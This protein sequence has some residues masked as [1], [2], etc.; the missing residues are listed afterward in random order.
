M[1]LYRNIQYPSY[2][3]DSR[4]LTPTQ[5]YTRGDFFSKPIILFFCFTDWISLK[6][7]YI[8]GFNERW[9]P[10]G[11]DNAKQW[12]SPSCSVQ[13]FEAGILRLSSNHQNICKRRQSSAS[14]VCSVCMFCQQTNHVLVYY[15]LFF[16]ICY[17]VGQE[18]LL[19]ANDNLNPVRRFCVW[20][21]K[22]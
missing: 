9:L 19:M 22:E 21:S 20:G 2:P 14:L 15:S 13:E 12:S 3:L 18:D 7:A 1:F 6:L 4:M 11:T 16:L 8:H 17:W 10:N 5:K